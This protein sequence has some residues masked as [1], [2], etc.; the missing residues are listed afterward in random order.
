MAVID[1]KIIAGKILAELKKLSTPSKEL[2]AVYV[3]DN[4]ASA[5]FL[6]QKAKVAAELGVVF[7]LHKFEAAI[8]EDELVK[9]IEKLGQND[10]VGGI[11]VQLP[12][13]EK[14]NRDRVVGSINPAKDID[15]LSPAAKV[16]PLAVEVVKDILKEVGWAI[17][18]KVIGVVGRGL[19]V[20]KPIAEWLSGKCKDL[21]IFHTQAD[22]SR[23]KD[24]DLVI[25]GVGKA[26]L[27]KPE[28][29]KPGA[30][31]IDFG[32]DMKDGKISGDL[33]S[34]SESS[35]SSLSSL[36]FYTPTPGGTGLILVAEIFRNLYLLTK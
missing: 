36:S 10:A 29:L 15:A 22:L 9:E 30:G 5:S 35:L 25:S 1:G 2:A 18:D 27:I 34:T 7:H 4:P 17:E 21:I 19:L 26:G 16:S 11:I 20:G 3:G 14:F 24:C 23:I 8:S 13:P 31:V 32:F 28:M 12:L 6:K 33:D